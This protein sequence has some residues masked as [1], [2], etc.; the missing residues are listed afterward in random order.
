M[1][2]FRVKIISENVNDVTS[3]YINAIKGLRVNEEKTKYMVLSRKPPNMDSKRS[4]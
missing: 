1:V 3:E 4:G 2:K